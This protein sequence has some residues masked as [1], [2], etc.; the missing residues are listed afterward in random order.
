MIPGRNWGVDSG[1]AY[2]VNDPFIDFSL[3]RAKQ[4]RFW[5]V[6]PPLCAKRYCTR[7][8]LVFGHQRKMLSSPPP[9]ARTVRSGLHARH[10][11]RWE[12]K[13]HRPRG[14]MAGNPHDVE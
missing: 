3:E 1:Y 13:H 11:M 14:T 6:I 7:L 10:L 9:L 4:S 12:W 5:D 2:T 8:V